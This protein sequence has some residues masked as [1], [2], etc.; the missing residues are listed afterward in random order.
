[1]HILAKL[2]AKSKY[3]RITIDPM[4]LGKLGA[5]VATLLS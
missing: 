5:T 4:K 2:Y 3:S 1:M